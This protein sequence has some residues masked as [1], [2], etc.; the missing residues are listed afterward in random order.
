LLLL[1]CPLAA[2]PQTQTIPAELIT[3]DSGMSSEY[4]Y[5]IFQDRLGF[6]WFGTSLGVARHDGLHY[7][8]FRRANT[9]PKPLSNDYILAITQDAAGDLWLGTA[10]GLNRFDVANETF[11]V[12]RHDPKDPASLSGN[13]IYHLSP[14][15]SR[16]GSLWVATVD[17]GLGLFDPKTGQCQSYRADP[18]QPGAL[19]SNEVRKVLED[20]RR[21]VWV[22]T[23]AGLYRF[24]PEAGSFE[25]F[26]HDPD[27]GNTISN[28]SVYEI[29]E[30]ER[31]PGILWV[32]VGGN[33][34]NRFDPERRA[35]ERF[36]LPEAG[37]PAQA[38]NPVYFIADC[39]DEPDL[40]L[41]GTRQG[42][43]RFNVIQ[44]SWQRIVL[45]DQFRETGDP[46]D[47]AILGIYHDRSGVCW[48]SV[49]GRGLIKFLPQPAFFRPHLNTDGNFDPMRRNRIFR[50]SESADGRIWLATG[51]GLFRCSPDVLA[52]EHV[53][54]AP[55]LPDR[56]GF[57]VVTVVATTRRGELWVATRG[58]LVRLDPL[59]GQQQVFA[60]RAGDASTL[61]FTQVAAIGDDAQGDV[62]IGSDFCLLRWNARTRS[63]KRYRHDPGDPGSLSG[64][65]VNPIMEDRSGDLWIGTENGLNLFDR[66]RDRFTRF[67]LDP[68]DPSKE[69]QNYVMFLHQDVKGRIWVGTSNGLNL[70][71]RTGAGVRFQHYSAPGSTLRNFIMGIV[72]DDE[73]NLWISSAGGLSRFDM[74][75]RTFSE[76]GGRD[77]VPSLPL[78]YGSCL[79]L[80]SG[81][82]F[83][84]GMRGMVSFKPWLARPN[85]YVPPLAFTDVQVWRR[86][87][88]IGGAS[89]LPRSITL[90]PDLVLPY[91]QNNLT[92]SFA[93]LSYVRP[94]KNQYAYRLDGRDDSWIEIG[95]D[96]TVTLDNLD[97][98]R[99]RLQ[100]RGSNND[101]VWNEEGISLRLRIRPPFWRTGWFMALLALTF[102]VLFLQWNRTRSRR[103]AARI[104]SEA[105]MEHYCDKFGISPRERE[106]I[107]LLMKGKSNKEIEDALFISIGTVKN[108]VYSIFQKLDVKNRGQ[109]LARFKNLQVK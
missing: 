47:E 45:Q 8:V 30:S 98:G 24:R 97:P 9:L 37:A 53:A 2:R 63:F 65:H 13:V 60:A 17:N 29:F 75:T 56:A 78:L 106:I 95:F 25:A 61:G 68:P 71:E 99:Y 28:D 15:S 51:A 91:D 62:W 22:A 16:P 40:L 27:N 49:Q 58:G 11:S 1:L 48:V 23:A 26:R 100:V 52:C 54:L 6:M 34:L 76:Y 42:L 72:E 67:Y 18:S 104:R 39:P 55:A 105:A 73:E 4:V 64:S 83:F 103:L 87:P 107:H 19:G 93:A 96:H 69:T 50:L 41:V 43:Y 102:I 66:A 33:A 38:R 36:E 44:G 94:E 46:G 82:I 108:H 79:R 101:G 31:R 35:W 92:F 80:R 81:E 77:R 86:T 32:G 57:D 5:S 10:N 109:L 70:M 74:R 14:W 21:R 20:S 88:A 85:R 3:A 59:T 89:P 84:G 7:K 90:A 12:Y